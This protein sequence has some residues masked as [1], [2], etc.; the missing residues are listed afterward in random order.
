MRRL[1]ISLLVL[2]LGAPLVVGRGAS[3]DPGD[4]RF[5][6][7][8]SELRRTVA[9]ERP[10]WKRRLDRIVS[11]KVISVS[12]RY[13]GRGLYHHR[14]Q[15]QRVPAS[16]QKLLLSL[17]LASRVEPSMR[18]RTVAASTQPLATGVLDGDLYIVGGGDP[19]LTGGGGYPRSL[20]VSATRLQ[21]LARAIKEAGIV[22]IQ[23]RV[24]GTT[25][26]FARDWWADGW[27]SHFP[28]RYIPLPTALTFN[29]NKKEGQHIDHPEIR[30]ARRLNRML[31]KRDIQVLKAPA[32]QPAPAG[33]IE[34]AGVD[35]APLSGLM[36][37]M[38]RRSSNFFAEVLNKRLSVEAGST[39]GTISGGAAAIRQTGASKGVTVTAHDGSGLSYSNRIST[40]GLTKL[41]QA[42][43]GGSWSVPL[44]NSLAAG[45]QGTLKDRLGDVQVRAKTGTL[46]SISSLSGWVWLERRG[47][48][49][50]FS[51][52]SRGMTKTK[53]S[54]VEDK[55]VRLV[56]QRAR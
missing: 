25:S 16:G 2:I 1:T 4:P 55:I 56:S 11:G 23:G 32:V 33:L 17:A 12:F 53:A 42:A 50:Q 43:P 46:S 51:I 31:K 21:A 10:A 48:W 34:V 14:G 20:G 38:N 3:S 47:G 9:T 35:S 13:G 15:K 40:K 39:P 41:L 45:G 44:R 19:T 22:R 49:A 5:T 37:H 8:S 52:M 54:A 6:D 24:V 36:R 30:V 27:K 26:F 28:S 29:G 18:I 7:R